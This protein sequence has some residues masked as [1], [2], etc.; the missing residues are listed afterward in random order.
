MG[1]KVIGTEC[2]EKASFVLRLSYHE[3]FTLTSASAFLF[4]GYVLKRVSLTSIPSAYDLPS[5][6]MQK[7]V[8]L[9][10]QLISFFK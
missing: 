7:L 9:C 1:G 5:V 3:I 10:H 2:S 6:M 4:D 8:S